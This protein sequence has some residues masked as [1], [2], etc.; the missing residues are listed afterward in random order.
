MHHQLHNLLRPKYQS[1]NS[2]ALSSQP[3]WY[4]IS[5]HITVVK[6]NLMKSCSRR[7]ISSSAPHLSDSSD[8]GSKFWLQ[9]I[10]ALPRGYLLILYTLYKRD[11][12]VS[13]MV[14]FLKK[15]TLICFVERGQILCALTDKYLIFV[16]IGHLLVQ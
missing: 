4:V 10:T 5:L 16:F 6:F 3:T 11:I 15:K 9:I 13:I 7:S 8:A 14:D 12:H 2:Y 1:C